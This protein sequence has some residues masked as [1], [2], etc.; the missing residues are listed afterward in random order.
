[1]GW[2]RQGRV[3]CFG[4]VVVAAAMF[5]MSPVAGT[6]VAQPAAVAWHIQS[7]PVPAGGGEFFAASCPS[8]TSCLAVGLSEEPGPTY[9]FVERWNGT[10]WSIVNTPGPAS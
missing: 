9:R 7:T 1:M 3:F 8:A 2:R 10:T 6:G 4:A 5:G